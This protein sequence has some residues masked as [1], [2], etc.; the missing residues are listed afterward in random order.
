MAR[1]S[2]LCCVVRERLHHLGGGGSLLDH[3]DL[4]AGHGA[5]GDEC[6]VLGADQ[7]QVALCRVCAVFCGLELT[8]EA[9]YAGHAL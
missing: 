6:A 7:R 8:L 3:V 5:G 2:R 4:G 1:G 9:A